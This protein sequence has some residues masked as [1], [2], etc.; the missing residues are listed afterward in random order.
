MIQIHHLKTDRAFQISFLLLDRLLQMPDKGIL[1]REVLLKI[2]WDAHTGSFLQL[3]SLLPLLGQTLLNL[4]LLN[5]N[6]FLL[7]F[8]ED[9]L[10]GDS[11]SLSFS[12][13]FYRSFYLF[14]PPGSERET[15]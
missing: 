10:I 12:S 15:I 11:L 8:Q 2:M 13:L 9:D 6:L 3:E 14:A 1:L 5:F 4:P 7:L